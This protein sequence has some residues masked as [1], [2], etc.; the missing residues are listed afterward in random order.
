M[1]APKKTD[2]EIFRNK[3]SELQARI[4]LYNETWIWLKN[5]PGDKDYTVISCRKIKTA[6]K[7]AK[8]CFDMLNSFIFNQ[9]PKH[10]EI[11]SVKKILDEL[12]KEPFALI[13]EHR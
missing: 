10:F 11:E 9:D 2:S 8:E 3:L 13:N 6:I 4:D 7:D 1:K 12:Q 5:Y